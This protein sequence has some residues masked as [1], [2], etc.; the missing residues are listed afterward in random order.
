MNKEYKSNNLSPL[1]HP[2]LRGAGPRMFLA[3][4]GGAIAGG[5]FDFFKRYSAESE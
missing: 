4:F 1:Q 5:L 3:T 2:L